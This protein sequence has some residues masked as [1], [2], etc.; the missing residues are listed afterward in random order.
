MHNQVYQ[1][2]HLNCPVRIF[3]KWDLETKN[4]FVIIHNQVYKSHQVSKE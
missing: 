1:S 2:H 4:Y 3:K